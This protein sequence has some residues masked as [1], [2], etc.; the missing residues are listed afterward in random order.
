VCQ[1]QRAVA[2]GCRAPPRSPEQQIQRLIDD[3]I[4]DV[5]EGDVGDLMDRVSAS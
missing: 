1:P 4:E 2:P 3:S 5:E